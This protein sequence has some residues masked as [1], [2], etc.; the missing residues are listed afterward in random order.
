MP[1]GSRGFLIEPVGSGLRHGTR[2]SGHPAA[3]DKP[4]SASAAEN[5]AGARETEKV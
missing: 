1:G 2:A 4:I 3:S 5:S